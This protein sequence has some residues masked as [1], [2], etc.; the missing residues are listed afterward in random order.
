MLKAFKKFRHYFYGIHFLLETDACV[1]V[2][3]LNQSSTDLPGAFFICWLVWIWLFDFEVKHVSG[4][5]HT[6]A[7]GF[8]KKPATAHKIKDPEN[9]DDFIAAELNSIRINFM[10]LDTSIFPLQD[11]Y[12]EK[13]V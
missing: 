9:I 2:S 5:K 6:A 4:Q 7:D 8:F 12:F 13:S 1:L 3:Q 10:A 11:G